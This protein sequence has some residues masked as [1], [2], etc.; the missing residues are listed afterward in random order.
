MGNTETIETID[1]I[2]V[3]EVEKIEEIEDS[4]MGGM[5]KIKK[6][7]SEGKNFVRER[8]ASMKG[9]IDRADGIFQFLLLLFG[10]GFWVVTILKMF[11]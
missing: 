2:E 8:K 10:L 4:E 3:E 6:I 9:K 1:N 11:L 7:N 5:N